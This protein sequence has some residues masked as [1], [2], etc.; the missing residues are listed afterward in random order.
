MGRHRPK[1][2]SLTKLQLMLA[3]SLVSTAPW[4]TLWS[5]PQLPPIVVDPSASI[6]QKGTQHLEQAVYVSNS[7]LDVL[8]VA[9]TLDTLMPVI[10]VLASFITTPLQRDSV[11]LRRAAEVT[12][13]TTN[14]GRRDCHVDLDDLVSHEE[15]LAYRG[16][17]PVAASAYWSLLF[18]D[19]FEHILEGVL[20]KGTVTLDPSADKEKEANAAIRQAGRDAYDKTYAPHHN[21]VV[22]AI[23]RR[24][25]DFLPPRE[26]FYRA[27]GDAGADRGRWG[28]H[29]RRDFESF[30][31]ASR[32]FVK[33]MRG[34]FSEAP[35]PTF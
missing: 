28:K 5:A 4:T 8:Q 35:A 29:L 25:F 17:R 18:L 31:K 27:L 21:R 16:H 2:P 6:L 34:H 26:V 30:L 12:L 32:P 14:C 15:D 19:F 33:R 3:F 24:V 22:R 9:E 10:T 1:E 7:S 13:E 23:A 11:N 20:R